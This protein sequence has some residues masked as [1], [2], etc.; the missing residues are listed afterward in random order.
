VSEACLEHQ[1]ATAVGAEHVLLDPDRVA[2]YAT[3][4][5]RRWTGR[6]LAVVRP[7]STAEVA[8]VVEICGALDV[9]IVPQGGNTGLV[10]G[11]VPRSDGGQ[12]VLSTSR[13]T[14]LDPVDVAAAQ[15]TVGAG[16]TLGELQRHARAAGF[17]Y[18]IDLAARDTATVGG[19]VATNAGGLHVIAAGDTRAQVLGIEAVLADGSVISR[20]AGLVKDNTG[21]DLA[22]L[23]TGS[24]GTLGVITAVRLRLAP[25]AAQSP[26]VVLVG[27][28]GIEAA[29]PL[30][31]QSG[32]TAAEFMTDAGMRL[33]VEATGLP[34]PLP[35]DHAVYLLLE[36]TGEPMLPED[37]EAAVDQRLWAYREGHTEAIA[38][39]GVPHK[40]DVSVP[41]ARIPALL[42][43]LPGVVGEY[44]TY[45][46][47]HLGDGNVHVNVLGPAP[48]DDRMDDA[49]LRLVA[50]HGGSIS[51]EHGIGV[52]K[53]RWLELSRSPTEIAAMRR[54]KAALDPRGL[55]NPGVLL[56]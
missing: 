22:G 8:A 23:L 15:V 2:S 47:G 17:S 26:Y 52:A 34:R 24:E 48:D 20:L 31:R 12:L 33:V 7:G 5:T 54:I 32:L 38:T 16:V 35:H 14:R 50:A 4:W 21:Y 3:D 36:C 19:T 51:A 37:V 6:P 44:E 18:S 39:R 9:P 53:T 56:P 10:G 1:L 43:D 42:A 30:L 27:L 25:P 28:P 45:V 13:L 46:F 40:L 41:L 49:V 29:L 11:G 55:L